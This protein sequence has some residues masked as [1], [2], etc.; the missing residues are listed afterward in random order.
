VGYALRQFESQ[1]PNGLAKLRDMYRNWPFFRTLVHNAEVS[2]AKADL[3]ISRQYAALVRSAGV[4]KKILGLMEAEH[5]RSVRMVFA[6]AQRS[7]LLENQPTLARSIRL[8]NPYVD[9]LSFL[10]IRFLSA[11]RHAGEKRCKEPAR[12]PLALTVK[13]VASGM[14]STG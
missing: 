5:A 6:V 1:E 7:A 11:W 14:K 4:G 10:Q 12:Q 9:P 2:L 13:G 3:G 8:R